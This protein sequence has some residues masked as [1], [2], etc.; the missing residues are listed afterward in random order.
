MVVVVVDGRCRGRGRVVLAD[1][2]RLLGLTLSDR[3]WSCIGVRNDRVVPRQ[4][5]SLMG[6]LARLAQVVV[7]IPAVMQ[8]TEND[9]LSQF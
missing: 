7:A 8:S 3:R 1:D 6:V 2:A 9:I 4:F 5:H